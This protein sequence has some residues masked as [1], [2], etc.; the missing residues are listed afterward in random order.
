MPELPGW[1]EIAH[2]NA[3][4]Q[5]ELRSLLLVADAQNNIRFL[6]NG[7]INVGMC[8]STPDSTYVQK[9]VASFDEN[10][11]LS[12]FSIKHD[13]TENTLKVSSH[14]TAALSSK[15]LF[16]KLFT[17]MMSLSDLARYVKHK[18]DSGV[19]KLMLDKKA[20]FETFLFDG[21]VDE[22][23]WLDLL[24]SG[25]CSDSLHDSLGRLNVP[26]KRR[27][28]VE[29]MSVALLDV[30]QNALIPASELLLCQLTRLRG[31]FDWRS[32]SEGLQLIDELQPKLI[33]LIETLY[34]FCH[35]IRQELET[36]TVFCDWLT[37]VMAELHPPINTDTVEPA[38]LPMEDKAKQ[39][40]K[41]IQTSLTA[42]SLNRFFRKAPVDSRKSLVDLMDAIHHDVYEN[43]E[44]Y[45]RT[46]TLSESITSLP[47]VTIASAVSE[48]NDMHQLDARVNSDGSVLVSYYADD[49]QL[50]LHRI[51]PSDH[52][53]STLSGIYGLM[54]LQF[55][56]D[57]TVF[58]LLRNADMSE[59]V[60]VI[61]I[62]ENLAYQEGNT[63]EVSPATKRNP[64]ESS[65]KRLRVEAG[66]R[67]CA[68]V[69]KDLRKLTMLEL[70]D[71]DDE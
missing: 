2:E 57:A 56:D 42:P 35:S 50:H 31:I 69:S 4:S 48:I 36:L 14:Q 7:W 64:V 45:L 30:C 65:I 46:S 68:V 55:Y 25:N 16:H 11:L 5:C 34:E 13:K 19:C 1:H 70:D 27:E 28:L 20:L 54:D 26:K 58:A 44:P 67:M 53:E 61:S 62:D 3:H 37:A 52:K 40:L 71:D 33:S 47:E 6:A 24:I 41:F 66:R 23:D 43:L 38:P 49:Q 39:V 18:F 32:S 29:F 22:S 51:T 12:V 17:T 60:A 15:Q 63:H 10:D 21:T 8:S 59:S 9:I